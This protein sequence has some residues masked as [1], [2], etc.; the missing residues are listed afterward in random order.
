MAAQTHLFKCLSDN[1]GVLIHDPATGATAS[2]DAPEAWA[3]DAALKET[4]WTLTDILVTHHHGDHTGGVAE[5]KERHGCK[6]TA[7]RHE[8]QPIPAVDATVAE[9]DTVTVG[10]LTARVLDTPGHT[11]GHI[12]YVFDADKIAFVGDTLFSIGCGRVIEG[13][14]EQMWASLLKLRALPDDT[15]IYCGHEYTLANIK[16]AQTIEPDNAALAARG[17]EAQQQIAAGRPTIPVMLGAEKQANP[18][19]RADVP[20]VA[21]AVKLAGKPA[22]QV[23]AEVRERKNRF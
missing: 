13:T 7:P 6:V 18:F 15:A 9:G 11:A 23:F 16:F 22:A 10:S 8:K 3:V 5:L 21:A 20:A 1:F 14:P 4:G 19:L 12:A 17:A 2:I